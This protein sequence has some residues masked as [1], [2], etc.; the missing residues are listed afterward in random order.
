M[1]SFFGI[2]FLIIIPL[3]VSLVAVFMALVVYVLMGL[4]PVVPKRWFLPLT[5]FYPVALLAGI[6]FTIYHYEQAQWL[7]WFVSMLQVLLGFWILFK[8]QDSGKF[9]WQ[10]VPVSRLTGRRFS[11][12]NLIG[13]GSLNLFIFMPAALLFLCICAVTAVDHFTDGFMA[14]H[15]GGFTVQVRKYVRDDGKTI[16]LFPMAHVAESEF[17]RKI[18]QEFPTNSIILMEGVTDEKNLLTNKITYK[19]MAKSLGLS[20]QHEQFAPTRG[21]IVDADID[22]DQFHTNTLAL[23]NLVMRLHAQ[24]VNQENLLALLQ[25]APSPNF[26]NELMDDL[27]GK[28]NQH[29]LSEIQVYL[30][31]SEYLVVPWGVAHMSGVSKEIQ[32]SG[33]KLTATQDYTVI[34]FSHPANKR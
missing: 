25:F 29:L 13:F 12:S 18:S 6:P 7:S 8:L 30:P 21:E 31:K 9:R 32:K 19:R 23:L 22:V 3:L 2:Q 10:L 28:R 5:L 1:I 15:R 24:G 33:F 20:E 16:Q 14:L 27:L 26:A 34:R 17:Y 11:W 4:T